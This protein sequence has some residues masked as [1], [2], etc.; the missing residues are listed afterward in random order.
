MSRS[1]SCTHTPPTCSIVRGFLSI[2]A[3]SICLHFY[4]FLFLYI[5]LSLGLSTSPLLRGFQLRT[6]ACATGYEARSWA[7]G[8][9]AQARWRSARSL[10]RSLSLTYTSLTPSLSRSL[11][12]SL[13]SL[14]FS[15]SQT[16]THRGSTPHRGVSGGSARSGSLAISALTPSLSRLHTLLCLSLSLL[17]RSPSPSHANTQ[18]FNS[19]PKAANAQVRRQSAALVCIHY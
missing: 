13:I 1:L 4:I 6:G 18:G 9:H 16:K 12:L 11:S 19:A 3:R 15:L 7:K 10:S 5:P 2:S 17:S 8:M 14:T